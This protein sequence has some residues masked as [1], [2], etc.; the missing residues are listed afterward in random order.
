[1]RFAEFLSTNTSCE[2]AS[3][4]K[5]EEDA[6]VGGGGMMGAATA[7]PATMAKTQIP[8]MTQSIDA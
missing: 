3:M 4:S 2:F 8:R 7:L 6:N 1:M 5:Y